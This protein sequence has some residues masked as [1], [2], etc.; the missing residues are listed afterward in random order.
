MRHFLRGTTALHRYRIRKSI[1]P[2]WLAS[3]SVHL[4]MDKARTNAVNTN[5]FCRYLERQS[6]GQRVN[7]AFGRCIVHIFSGRPEASSRRR[8]VH[9]RPTLSAVSQRH[10]SNCFPAAK[11][12][13]G[14]IR[15]ENTINPGSIH[16]FHAD[17]WQQNP[18]IIDERDDWTQLLVNCLEHANDID[19]SAHIR[20]HRDC[21]RPARRQLADN[22]IG[23]GFI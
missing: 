15:R 12:R 9:D 4:G 11:K 20:S 13:T 19:F 7:R 23:S 16:V 14:Y 5:A 17:L 8:H 1:D 10:A 21:C 3:R 6:P 22:G 18:R 2:S